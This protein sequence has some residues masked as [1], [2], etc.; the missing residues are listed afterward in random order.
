MNRLFALPAFRVLCLLLLA[1]PRVALAGVA[2]PAP[3]PDE[4]FDVMNLLDAKGLH[5]LR[6]ERWN[7]YG[8]VT[9]ISNWKLPFSAPYTNQNGSNHSLLPGF[10]HAFTGTATLFLGLALWPG[11]AVYAVPEVISEKPLSNLAGLGGAIQNFELQK[12]GAM[13]PTLYRSRV[14]LR[15]IIGL[16]G[17]KEELTSDPMQLGAEVDKR[18]VVLTLGNL[19]V[20]DVF[21]KNTFAG[22]LRRQF[23]NMAFLTHAAYDFAADARGYSWGGVAEVILDDWAFRVARFA[24]PTDPNQLDID[25][26][27]HKHYGDQLEVEHMHTIAGQPGA[28]RAIVYHNHERLGR[29]DEAIA[30]WK[31]DGR[32]NAAACTGFNY[33]SQNALAPDLCWA[34]RENDKVGAGLNLEQQ[35]ADNYGLFLRGFVSDGQGE[36]YSFTSADRSLSLGVLAHGNDWKRDDDLAG[37]GLGVSWISSAHAAYLALGGVDGF[38]GD[39]ALQAAAEGVTEA[40]YSLHLIGPTWASGDYQFIFHPGYN[41]A[42]GPVHIFGARFHAEF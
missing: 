11:A 14:F 19:S 23:F 5:D 10:E 26:A 41:A 39:G 31:R 16:G 29:F 2:E 35:V 4:A 12:T 27:L 21:D 20:L 32:R 42:R 40:F 8:Q 38:V 36:V 7:A 18:R 37:V 24:P 25:W 30:A 9:W 34:R 17:G 33:G 13:T 3:R 28:V 6:H 22:D 15:Q 1:V